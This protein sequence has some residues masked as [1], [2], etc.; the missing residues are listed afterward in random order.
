M[1]QRRGRGTAAWCDSLLDAAVVL[2]ATWTVV[3]HLCLVTH[4]GTTWAMVLELAALVGTV[5]GLRRLAPPG[6][7]PTPAPPLMPSADGVGSRGRASTALVAVA[8]VAAIVAAVATARNAS[9][10]LVWAPWLTSAL[11]STGWAAIRLGAASTASPVPTRPP[12]GRVETW[13]APAWAVGLGLFSWWVLDPNTDDLFYLNLSQAVADDGRFPLRDTLFSRLDLPMANWPPVA[14]YDAL[15]GVVARVLGV[16]AAGVAYLGVLPVATALSVLALWRLLRAWRVRGVACALSIALV[17]LLFD[18]GVSYATPGNLFLTRLWQGK[19]ILLCVLVP[20]LLVYALRY[21]ESPTRGRLV[22][23]ALGSAAAVG[24]STT[25]IFL[26]PVIAVGGTAPLWGRAPRRALVGLA[27]LAAYPLGAGVVSLVVGGRSA[28]DFGE[29]LLYRFDA[30]WIGH[31]IF[32]DGAMALLGV[33]AV[34]LGAI[35]VPHPA[36]RLTTAVLALATG[37][38]LVPGATRLSYDLTG[39]G[40]TLWRLSWVATVAAL[41][42]VA[43]ARGAHALGLR[44]PRHTGAASGPLS[45]VFVLVVMEAFGTPIWS[46]ASSGASLRAP[47][48]WQR[49]PPSL[50]AA[51]RLLRVAPPGSRVLAPDSLSITLAVSTSDLTTVAPREYYLQYLEHDP[52]FHYADRLALWSFVNDTVTTPPHD[53]RG[54]LERVGV[55]V[56]CTFAADTRSYADVRALGYRPLVA[57]HDYRCLGSA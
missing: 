46:T 50:T 53:L 6:A 48:H 12:V 10:A 8:V 52:S 20:V 18:G 36:G 37:V 39:L 4:L 19:I 57:T 55:D 28:D 2:L 1:S 33:L 13:V 14:S 42:G 21:V 34:L 31:Q 29:R 41:L 32:L 51:Q 35:L 26:L 24:L 7:G 25:A 45:V 44:L 11:A 23:L 22:R 9:F 38:V 40:P 49:P 54:S 3:Y 15:V 30:A 47:F 43:V 27:A 5:L 56:V 16:H 17:F